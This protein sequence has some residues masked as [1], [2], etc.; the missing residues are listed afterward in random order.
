MALNQMA[1]KLSL[2]VVTSNGGSAKVIKARLLDSFT[3]KET[4]AKI[5]CQWLLQ[6][7]VYLETQC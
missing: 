1:L 3:R 5:M 6:V 7:K 2:A 4:K